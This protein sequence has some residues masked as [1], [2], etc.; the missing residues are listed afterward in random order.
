[1]SYQNVAEQAAIYARRIMDLETENVELRRGLETLKEAGIGYSQQTVD[2]ITK[3][4]EQLRADLALARAVLDTA[5]E[6]QRVGRT[7]V[8]LVVPM[9]AWQRWG[10]QR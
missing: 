10:A 7:M 9:A 2:A 4:R 8:C 5:V 3:E 1:M 6:S